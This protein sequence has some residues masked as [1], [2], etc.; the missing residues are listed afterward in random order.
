[1]TADEFAERL[2]WTWLF[3]LQFFQHTKDFFSEREVRWVRCA[4]Y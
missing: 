1:M 4:V 3:D 2:G